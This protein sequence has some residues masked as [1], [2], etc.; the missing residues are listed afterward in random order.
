[1]RFL[2]LCCIGLIAVLGGCGGSGTA[3]N[4][5]VDPVAS[6]PV[7]EL[8]PGQP[9]AVYEN[10]EGV[11]LIF[12]SLKTTVDESQRALVQFTGVRHPLAGKVVLTTA[13]ILS[14]GTFIWQVDYL[15]KPRTLVEVRSQRRRQMT[16]ET[17]LHLPM[18]LAHSKMVF[19]R[20]LTQA[21]NWQKLAQ[22]HDEQVADG[23]LA[24]LAKAKVFDFELFK[25]KRE[26]ALERGR[27]RFEKACGA[28]PVEVDW[29]TVEG[30]SSLESTPCYKGISTLV[31]V[32][33]RSIRAGEV[34]RE[35]AKKI[36][37]ESADKNGFR[38]DS[39]GTLRITSH[40]STQVEFLKPKVRKLFGLGRIVARNASGEVLVFNPDREGETSGAVSWG[41]EVTM[42]KQRFD[43]SYFRLWTTN[44]WASLYMENS[45]WVVSCPG[46]RKEFEELSS[47]QSQKLLSTASFGE[48]VWK[49]KPVSL[50]RDQRGQYFY[51]DRLQDEFGGK[52]Y[53]VYKGMRGNLQP[54]QLIDI[55][56][57]PSGKVF[58]TRQGELRLLLDKNSSLWIAGKKKS[59]LTQVWKPNFEDDE[60]GAKVGKL[61][62]YGLGVYDGQSF[63]TVCD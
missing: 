61:I 10:K 51:V 16:T 32:C 19:S 15:G 23:S 50:S 63:G 13:K 33:K 48:Q 41:D 58:S 24:S 31:S 36:V 53:R 22:V 43:R 29:S 26:V 21:L 38:L 47:A 39:K 56:D 30:V 35:Q 54:T 2:P 11:T 44:S 62:Y 49:R 18:T 60:P 42:R 46:E 59:P 52:D 27:A 28:I 37:C 8:E 14:T 1:M 4:P 6:Q 40:F 5:T 12:I 34:I 57:D 55:I 25:N 17:I 9:P 45:K 7:Y 20:D 3:V